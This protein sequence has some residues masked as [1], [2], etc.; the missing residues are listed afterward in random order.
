MHCN[1]QC[2]LAKELKDHEQSESAPVN[3]SKDKAE[4]IIYLSTNVTIAILSNNNSLNIATPYFERS[5][6]DYSSLPFQPP[7]A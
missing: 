4:T 5:L 7:K 6:A 2:H 3:S 1:G